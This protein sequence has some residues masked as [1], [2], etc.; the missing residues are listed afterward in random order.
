[1]PAVP[2]YPASAPQ[3]SMNITSNSPPRAP[4][5]PGSAQP[6]PPQGASIFSLPGWPAPAG[7]A[8]QVVAAPANGQAQQVVLPVG[9]QA[10]G[11]QETAGLVHYAA[12]ELAKNR[13]PQLVEKLLVSQGTSPELANRIVTQT[14]QALKKARRD[15]SKS[16]MMWG[17]IWAIGG[18]LVTALTYA[19]AGQLGGTYFVFYG[20]VIW[21]LIDF[22]IGLA[23]WLSDR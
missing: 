21:G 4:A 14:S 1:M 17:L 15:K 10:V 6:A 3:P 20:A 23:G 13:P 16:R 18:I 7:A 2:V 9:S 5:P 11:Q 19:F 22:F 8:Q 12:S